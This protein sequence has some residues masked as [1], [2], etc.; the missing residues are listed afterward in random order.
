MNAIAAATPRTSHRD[1]TTFLTPGQ[2]YAEAGTAVWRV[3][4]Q[5]IVIHVGTSGGAARVTSRCP[6]GHQIVMPVQQFE[7]AVF[8]GQMVPVAGAGRVATC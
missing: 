5:W 4:K 6:N 7:A 8:A 1:Q 3:E 2:R